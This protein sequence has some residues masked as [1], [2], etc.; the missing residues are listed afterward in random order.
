MAEF[1][2]LSEERLLSRLQFPPGKVRMVLDTDTYNEIDDQ[3]ALVYALLCPEKL[4]VE[5]VYAAPFSND[6]SNGPGDGMEKSYEEILRLLE[7]MNVSPE[8]LVYRGSTRYLNEGDGPPRSEAVDDLIRR[9]LASPD[10]DPLYVVAIGAITNVAAALLL[11]PEIV[12]KIVVVWLG[13]NTHHSPHTMEFNL[14]Q[15]PDAARV[16][17]DCGVPFVQI[18]CLGVASHLLTT[19]T[20]LDETLKGRNDISDFLYQRFIE[21]SDNHFAWA[22]EIWD[23]SAVAYLLN[24]SWIPSEIVPSPLISG[25]TS[26]VTEPEVRWSGSLR[27]VPGENR[28]PMKAAWFISRNPI[29]RDL[30]TRLQNFNG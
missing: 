28:H 3:F 23:I 17:F 21:Y 25:E 16:I 4:K 8:G 20:E 18:P 29:F 1:P 15:D 26:Y 10:D 22:K 24:E 11:E 7:R 19:K 12:H 13:G 30:L 5:A 9:A 2:K 6:R 27:F 14:M